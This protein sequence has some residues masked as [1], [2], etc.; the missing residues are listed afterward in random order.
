MSLTFSLFY[1]VLSGICY[2]VLPIICTDIDFSKPVCLSNIGDKFKQGGGIKRPLQ[3]LGAAIKMMGADFCFQLPGLDA[4][5]TDLIF[6]LKMKMIA[7]NKDTVDM[8]NFLN[9][10]PKA[11]NTMTK[12]M[13]GGEGVKDLMSKA[14]NL[15]PLSSCSSKICGDLNTASINSKIKEFI[16]TFWPVSIYIIIKAKKE[17]RESVCTFLYKLVIILISF[18]T[19]LKQVYTNYY[20]SHWLLRSLTSIYY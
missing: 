18:Q 8:N 20:N 13:T 19:N 15:K 11:W 1:N 9:L 14:L 17:E 2:N 5:G 10:L 3:A 7:F 4:T 16:T 12:D 6:G